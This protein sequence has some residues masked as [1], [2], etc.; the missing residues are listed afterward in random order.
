M[1][2]PRRMKIRRLTLLTR[3]ATTLMILILRR[4]T[5]SVRT[6]TTR[7]CK[8]PFVY[9]PS[10][11]L[12]FLCSAEAKKEMKMEVSLKGKKA[13]QKLEP[14]TEKTVY[15]ADMGAGPSVKKL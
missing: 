11:G 13:E 4:K 9:F 14:L 2:G 12:I 15:Y 5:R 1:L 10:Q 6:P 3:M 8:L 7:R